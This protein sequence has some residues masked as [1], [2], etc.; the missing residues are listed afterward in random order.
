MRTR[1]K[2]KPIHAKQ[3][4][5]IVSYQANNG[6]IAGRWRHYAV[7][8]TYALLLIMTEVIAELLG[9]GH[10]VAILAFGEFRLTQRAPRTLHSNLTDQRY[11]LPIHWS[12][13]F[14]PSR[15]LEQMV[16]SEGVW[17]GQSEE[18]NGSEEKD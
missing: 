18:I 5:R 1:E 16:N 9:Q 17:R 10:E 6:R 15:R 2:A 4:A 3:L 11:M 14:K 7:E 13:R 12:V 8:E